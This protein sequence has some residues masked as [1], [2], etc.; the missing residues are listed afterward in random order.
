[1]NPTFFIPL[2][3]FRACKDPSKEEA[4][5][6]VGGDVVDGDG[7][8]V[9]LVAPVLVRTILPALCRRVRKRLISK[10]SF[11]SYPPLWPLCALYVLFIFLDRSPERGGRPTAWVRKARFWRYF[12][13]YYPAW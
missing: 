2:L 11:S 4:A 8:L 6:V 1:M 10:P 13:E 7:D 3:Q 9:L 5:D 12:A